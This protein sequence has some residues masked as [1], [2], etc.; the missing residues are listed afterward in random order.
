MATPKKLKKCP[1]HVWLNQPYKAYNE[2]AV[3]GKRV[4]T[5]KN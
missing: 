2:C 4:A 5:I 3:C 1:R